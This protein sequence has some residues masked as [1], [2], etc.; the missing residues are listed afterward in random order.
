MS[1]I[2]IIAIEDP[3]PD[4][5]QEFSFR[6]GFPRTGLHIASCVECWGRPRGF[7]ARLVFL[8]HELKRLGTP[9]EN[10]SDACFEIVKNALREWHPSLICIAA[11]YTRLASLALLMASYCKKL[12]HAPVITGGPH[13]SNHARRTLTKPNNPFDAIIEGAG[14]AKLRHIIEHLPEWDVAFDYPGIICKNSPDR[15]HTSP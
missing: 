13:F 6:Y 1:N 7:Q 14:E 10:F 11:P 3:W 8:D 12:S 5:P 15:P 4:K 2:L 9:T